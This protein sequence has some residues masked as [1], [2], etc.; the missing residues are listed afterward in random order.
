[1]KKLSKRNTALA[2]VILAVGV[3]AAAGTAMFVSDEADELFGFDG[4]KVTQPLELRGRWLGMSLASTDSASARAQQIPPGTEGVMVLEIA[5]RDGWRARQAGVRPGDVVTKVDGNTVADMADF[6]DVS[7]TT[8]VSQAIV[9]D[10]Q[11]WGQ[12]MSLVLPAAA[13]A[14]AP[15]QAAAPGAM[16]P[17]GAMAP[18]AVPAA[19]TRPA[20]PMYLC[21]GHGQLFSQQAVHPHYR[22]PLCNRQLVQQIP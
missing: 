22:C 12:P 5:E 2:V 19:Q 13:V 11:R 4:K 7:R 14:A 15:P 21:P 9:L 8:D 6:Y 18:G 10:V 1:M 3:A 20:G 16:P 17:P